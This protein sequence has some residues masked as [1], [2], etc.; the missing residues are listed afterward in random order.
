[1]SGQPNPKPAGKPVWLMIATSLVLSGALTVVAYYTWTLTNQE[2]R[3]WDL[4]KDTLL[5]DLRYFAGFL[6]VFVVL[7]VIDKLHHLIR[8]KLDS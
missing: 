1:M 7:T 2:L 5:T 8:S 4:T 6:A 3:Q